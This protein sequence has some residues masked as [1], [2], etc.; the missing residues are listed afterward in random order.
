MFGISTL[1][2]MWQK[3]LKRSMRYFLRRVYSKNLKNLEKENDFW[4]EFRIFQSLKN[5]RKSN[6]AVF[7]DQFNLVTDLISLKKKTIFFALRSN[8]LSFC[9]N[10]VF[11][12]PSFLVFRKILRFTLSPSPASP[13][14]KSWIIKSKRTHFWLLIFGYLKFSN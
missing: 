7:T 8:T 12:F 14:T 13:L 9:F 6:S 1:R 2:K 4:I 11:L 3:S 10:V 5:M